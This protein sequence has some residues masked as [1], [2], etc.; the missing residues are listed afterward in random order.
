MLIYLSLVIF[1][2]VWPPGSWFLTLEKGNK[3]L[4]SIT[5]KHDTTC[6]LLILS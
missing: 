6:M 2:V 5:I 1:S 4:C 3:E